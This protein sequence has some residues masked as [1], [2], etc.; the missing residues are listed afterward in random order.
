MAWSPPNTAIALTSRSC[1]SK[2]ATSKAAHRPARCSVQR[3]PWPMRWAKKE[4]RSP[5]PE[6]TWRRG[7]TR[8]TIEA[9]GPAMPPRPVRVAITCPTGVAPAS[10]S[11]PH[12][13]RYA[14]GRQPR[15]PDEARPRVAIGDSRPP[16]RSHQ[17]P[18]AP[19]PPLEALGKRAQFARAT[20][21]RSAPMQCFRNDP[22][23]LYLVG[24]GHIV[25]LRP[26]PMC[27]DSAAALSAWMLSRP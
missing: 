23:R 22:P 19:D 10:R 15:T 20:L 9:P 27:G 4:C 2:R 3:R 5:H 1:C 25:H 8:T 16:L 18:V 13:S 14:S 26:R 21:Q 17:Q 7:S 6:A 24:A 12:R 11:R